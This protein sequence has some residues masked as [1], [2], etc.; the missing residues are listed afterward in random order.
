M[1]KTIHRY[2]LPLV[3]PSGLSAGED[4]SGNVITIARD[5]AGRPV[6]RGSSLAGVL[7]QAWRNASNGDRTLPE[8][9][10]IFGAA[11]GASEAM[12]TPSKLQIPDVLIDCGS[13]RELERTHQLINRHTGSVLSGALFS[14][15]ALP[16]QA[17]A[18]LVLWLE[19][20]G[21]LDQ[22]AERMASVFAGFF[23]DGLLVGGK[24][25]R[26]VGLARLA[27]P[28]VYR[29]YDMAKSDDAAAWL[30]DHRNWRLG[31]PLSEG[32]KVEPESAGR[33]VLVV[34]FTLRIPRGQDCLIG[35]GAG[36]DSAVKAQ[37]VPAVDGKTYWRLPGSSLRGVMRNWVTRLA[38]RSGA[39]V[40][41]SLVCYRSFDDEKEYGRSLPWAHQTDRSHKTETDCV[42][43]KLFGWLNQA[44][45]IHIAD[46][47]SPKNEAAMQV[48]AHVAVDRVTGGACEG[49][50]FQTPTLIGEEK[51]GPAFPVRMIIRD[52]EERE[53]Q[54]LADTLK[55]IHIG[56]L[57]I[58]SSKAGGRL[59]LSATPEARGKFHEKFHFEVRS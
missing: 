34:D 5:G 48:R 45:R 9:E 27:A 50:F 8:N 53:A 10:K 6:L 42:I 32:R 2:S 54:W 47:L 17:K 23:E 15:E 24:S 31:K 40:A 56:V 18:D 38:V 57:R 30:D 14:L 25:N 28:A 29:R 4:R 52:P 19:D 21:E 11:K 7:R 12:L 49:F 41:D 13:C 20:S 46:S 43:S 39:T 33:D 44:G 37:E 36:F 3:F 16:P 1:T 26:G 35:D 58:G 59:A 22:D 55:A 51:V